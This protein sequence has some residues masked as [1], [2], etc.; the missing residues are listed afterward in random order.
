MEQEN[1]FP[2]L[3]RLMEQKIQDLDLCLKGN[4]ASKRWQQINNEMKRERAALRSLA[5]KAYA[6]H[7]ASP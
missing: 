2:R 5:Q 4:P 3:M 6:E 7:P 1:E